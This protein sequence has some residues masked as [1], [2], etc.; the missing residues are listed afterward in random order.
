MLT[1]LMHITLPDPKKLAPAITMD[2]VASV[3][4][5][6]HEHVA[7]RCCRLTQD[8]LVVECRHA[9]HEKLQVF[10]LFK[11]YSE[12]QWASSMHQGAFYASA[13]RP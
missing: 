6:E 13:L 12:L 7:D 5:L 4:C 1:I 9:V 3:G 8:A 11:I 2:S 10:C